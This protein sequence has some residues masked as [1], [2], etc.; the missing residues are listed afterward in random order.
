LNRLLKV[1]FETRKQWFTPVILATWEAEMRRN[2]IRSQ[3]EQI[4][5]KTLSQKNTQCTKKGLAEWLKW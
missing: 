5:H 1:N 2:A 3:S 4:V